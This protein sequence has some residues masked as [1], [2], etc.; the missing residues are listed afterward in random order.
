MYKSYNNKKIGIV[1]NNSKNNL[2]SFGKNKNI[3]KKDEIIEKEEKKPNN[4]YQKNKV[5]KS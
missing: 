4:F 1:N 3:I 2:F 5:D